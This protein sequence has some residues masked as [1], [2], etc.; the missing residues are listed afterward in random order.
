LNSPML[1]D[2][3]MAGDRGFDP[4]GFADSTARLTEFRE[5]EI[6]HARLA[7]LAR[8]DGL[9]RNSGTKRLLVFLICLRFW[10]PRIVPRVS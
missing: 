8:R 9:Y 2:G 4:F 5:A 1:L 10:T 6:K 7:M 3:T